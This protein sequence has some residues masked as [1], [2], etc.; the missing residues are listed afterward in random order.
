MLDFFKNQKA[1]HFL[2]KLRSKF[3]Q[4]ILETNNVSETRESILNVVIMQKKNLKRTR[5]NDDNNNSNSNINSNRNQSKPKNLKNNKLSQQQK[6]QQSRQIDSF[7][8]KRYQ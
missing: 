7:V 3:K 5:E 1:F 2:I 8:R 6:Q 4:K